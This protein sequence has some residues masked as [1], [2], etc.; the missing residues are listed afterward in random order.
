M[1]FSRPIWKISPGTA[2]Q[3][4]GGD[5]ILEPCM[6]MY[7]FCIDIKMVLVCF[8]VQKYYL[9]ITRW[10]KVYFPS[11][12]QCAIDLMFYEWIFTTFLVNKTSKHLF[13]FFWNM[14]LKEHNNFLGNFITCYSG[15]WVTSVCL[16]PLWYIGLLKRA[17]GPRLLCSVQAVT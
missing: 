17:G 5:A 1:K 10:Y 16:V 14:S 11:F 3:R 13:I 2:M 15:D 9:Q 7:R 8:I 12:I 6:C 4:S